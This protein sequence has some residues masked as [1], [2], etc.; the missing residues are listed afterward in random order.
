MGHA[1][2]PRTERKAPKMKA[3][4]GMELLAIERSRRAADY[5]Y[6]AEQQPWWRFRHRRWLHHQS[7]IETQLWANCMEGFKPGGITPLP[8]RWHI[9]AYGS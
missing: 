6:E 1:T 2:N 9:E 3:K 7:L 8:P 5:W 4:D